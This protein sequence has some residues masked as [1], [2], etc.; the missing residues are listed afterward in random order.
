MHGEGWYLPHASEVY[1]ILVV[2]NDNGSDSGPLS[3]MIK[4]HGGQ[5][6]DYK[7]YWSSCEEDTEKAFNFFSIKKKRK[8]SEGKTDE[9]GVRAV[10]F[11]KL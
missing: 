9:Q 2:A 4:F 8:V 5:P 1:H 6:L 11:F 7:Y 10:R 3:S